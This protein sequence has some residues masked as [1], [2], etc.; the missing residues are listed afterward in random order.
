NLKKAQHKLQKEL[1]EKDCRM[2]AFYSLD[3]A[4]IYDLLAEREKAEYYYRT[5]L[6]YLDHAKFQPLWITREGC[7]SNLEIRLF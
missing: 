7:S 4:H 3:A 5:T 2:A 1:K 6:K